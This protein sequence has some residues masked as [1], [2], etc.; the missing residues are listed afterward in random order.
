MV[1][2]G[3]FEPP[4][5]GIRAL[6][7]RI[8]FEPVVR[9]LLTARGKDRFLFFFIFFDSYRGKEY[10]FEFRFEDLYA[11]TYEDCGR[12]SYVVRIRIHR[13][14]RSLHI[15]KLRFNPCNDHA[16]DCE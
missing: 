7:R 1:G 2:P 11:V 14:R 10:K 4:G 16:A 3:R 5:S 12:N 8:N 6:I 13:I 15:I 9:P